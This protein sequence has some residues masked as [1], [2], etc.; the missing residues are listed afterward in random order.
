[1]NR[2]V[3]PCHRLIC[4]QAPAWSRSNCTLLV[5]TW[6]WSRI[7]RALLGQHKRDRANS[8]Q[9]Q[10]T[11]ACDK[12]HL[13]RG[14]NLFVHNVRFYAEFQF[15]SRRKSRLYFLAPHSELLCADLDARGERVAGNSQRAS[16]NSGYRRNLSAPPLFSRA[17]GRRSARPT[18]YPV[19]QAS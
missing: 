4:S 10:I 6:L 7:C 5:L 15:G 3:L 2:V 12:T 19:K 13:D 17:S 9:H 16:S 18:M 11:R 8:E 14:T 1:M